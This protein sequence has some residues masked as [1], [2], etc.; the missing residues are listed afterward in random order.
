M[1]KKGQ[2]IRVTYNAISSEAARDEGLFEEMN[3]VFF[4]ILLSTKKY[5]YIAVR[6]LI[7]VE[8]LD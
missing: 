1:L 3:E 2:K 4:I 7:R 8:E 5:K 6:K